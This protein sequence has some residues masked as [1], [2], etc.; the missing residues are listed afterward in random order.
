LN[1]D[2]RKALAA[3][4]GCAKGGGN[5]GTT[6]SAPRVKVVAADAAFVVRVGARRAEA[7]ARDCSSDDGSGSDGSSIDER[8][9]GDPL[10]AVDAL[11]EEI[12]RL[13]L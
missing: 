3:E 12:R 10:E 2:A 11:L 1:A 13:G 9:E 8:A 4:E 5:D 6:R 7:A